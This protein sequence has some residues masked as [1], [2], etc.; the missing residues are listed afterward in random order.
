MENISL[1]DAMAQARL[2][3]RSKVTDPLKIEK[4][5][6]RL[7]KESKYHYAGELYALMLKGNGSAEKRM[8]WHRHLAFCLYKDPDL[9]SASKFDTA[10]VYLS[11]ATPH[12]LEFTQNADLLGMAGSIYKRKWQHDNQFRNL[13]FSE[14]YYRKGFESWKYRHQ[15]KSDIDPAQLEGTDDS[16]YTAIN[17]AFVAELIAFSRFK[18]VKQLKNADVSKSSLSRILSAAETRRYII[19]KQLGEK[20]IRFPEKPDLTLGDGLDKW[21]LTTLAEAY[22]GIGEFEGA[23]FFFKKYRSMQLAGWQAHTTAE[24]LQRQAEIHIQLGLFLEEAQKATDG[25]SEA[26]K[27]ILQDKNLPKYRKDA[28]LAA[29]RDCLTILYPGSTPPDA[30]TLSIAFNGKVGLAL[31]GG[32]F[33]AALFHVGVLARLAELNVLRHVEVLS[34]VSGGSIAGAYYYMLV[35]REMEQ[36][37]DKMNQMHYIAIVRE[38]EATFLR[39]IQKNLRMRIFTNPWKNLRLFFDKEYTRTHRLGELYEKYLYQKII[40][41]THSEETPIWMH[42]LK[43]TPAD[44]P[45]GSKFNPKTENWNRRNKV[46]MLVLNAT[47]LNTGHNW[48]FTASWM[49]EPP[50]NIQQDVD[51]KQRL[52]RMYYED[53]PE[54]YKDRIRLGHA[55]GASSC[56]PVLFEPLMLRG[57]YPGI[58]LQLVD[59]GVHDNQGVTSL[60]EQECKV[61]IVSDASGQL[62]DEAT[63]S[64]N[65]A[66]VFF[67]SDLVLQ[68]RVRESQLLDL[69][70]R[71]KAAQLTA[72]SFVHLKKELHKDPVNWKTC[73]EPARTTAFAEG[74]SKDKD[75]TSYLV[76]HD[77][78]TALAAVRTDLDAFNDAEAYALMYS[79]YAQT[80]LD[81]KDPK[82]EFLVAT[83]QEAPQQTWKFRDIE[84]RM[85][86]LAPSE[87]LLRRLNLGASLALKSFKT[88]WLNA[89]FGIIIGAVL[90]GGIGVGL[91][92]YF[93]DT[94]ADA[95]IFGITPMAIGWFVLGYL[96]TLYIGSFVAKA[97]SWQNTLLKSLGLVVGAFLLSGVSWFYVLVLNP[98]YLQYGKLTRLDREDKFKKVVQRIWDILR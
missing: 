58:D 25:Q 88:S 90:L 40:Q 93:K 84:P 26:S 65:T 68:E 9:P 43:I 87:N 21:V 32:G 27:E 22:F 38:M 52:R 20:Y 14:H 44:L 39:G 5:A 37:G 50:G 92:L 98:M 4:L 34:C 54:P 56:V 82:F 91:Y 17:Y 79:G 47:S 73:E 63:A 24:Q 15:K 76:L 80:T 42:T 78:Q 10:L 81:F 1:E 12:G 70:A 57:L 11:Q 23:K 18:E 41:N 8:E 28:I 45:P 96:A 2:D 72:F 85:R 64:G 77:V 94:P 97:M 53:A 74:K 48:Q 66:G 51:A 36:H 61:M 29:A 13:I 71:E 19:E 86:H 35:K 95:M 69:K 59:G 16:G 83:D 89:L 62:S 30:D 7:R 46:P 55:V 67:R 33:R 49:G 3:I 31:S 75:L 6:D 60:L